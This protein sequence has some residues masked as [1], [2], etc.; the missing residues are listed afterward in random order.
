MTPSEWH[1]RDNDAGH[2]EMQLSVYLY[3]RKAV[4]T[5]ETFI[6]RRRG[7]YDD[8]V[9]L[10]PR[11]VGVEFPL[12]SRKTGVPL[13]FSDVAVQFGGEVKNEHTGIMEQHR[14]W[15][16]FELKPAIKSIGALL[17]QCHAIKAAVARSDITPVGLT[18]GLQ[19]LGVD[20]VPVIY[21]NDPKLERLKDFRE[22]F[23][24]LPRDGEGFPYA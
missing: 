3:W 9:K 15:V 13:A 1:D 17:R 24:A 7:F 16:L 12:I 19:F 22:E 5:G 10:T 2:D 14:L 20:V 6:W 11:S 8:P 21:E 18:A 4:S 23:V